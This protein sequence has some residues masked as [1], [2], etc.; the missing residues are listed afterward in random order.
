MTAPAVRKINSEKLKDA[1]GIGA[2]EVG[3]TVTVYVR[4]KE[5]DKERLQA[6]KGIVI[7]CDGTGRTATFTVRRVSHGVGVE[8]VFPLHSQYI[9]KVELES[10]GRVRRSKIYYLRRRSGKQAKVEQKRK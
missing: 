1:D 5:G 7:A 8:R 4:I 3:N 10:A 6:Y 2:V 9:S